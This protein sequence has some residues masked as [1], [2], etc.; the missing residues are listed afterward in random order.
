MLDGA[1]VD[2][3]YGPKKERENIK[4][5]DGQ[6]TKNNVRGAAETEE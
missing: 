5:D 2:A 4:V 3:M 6:D 1:N